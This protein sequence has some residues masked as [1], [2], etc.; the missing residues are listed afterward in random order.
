[1][2]QIAF[3]VSD[4][5]RLRESPGLL[6]SIR[7]KYRTPRSRKA[8]TSTSVRKLLSLQRIEQVI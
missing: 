6:R 1:M 3:G 7:P 8:Y 5:S 4:R 2:A